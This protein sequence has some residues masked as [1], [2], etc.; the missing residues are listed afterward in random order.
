M[1][2]LEEDGFV[3]TGRAE[4]AMKTRRELDD[5]TEERG[6]CPKA[7]LA[8]LKL[9]SD[10]MKSVVAAVMTAEGRNRGRTVKR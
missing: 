3:L 9:A 6:P 7:K 5:W 1:V 10:V 4:A 8:S 2:G